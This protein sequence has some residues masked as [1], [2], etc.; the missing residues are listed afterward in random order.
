MMKRR[1]WGILVVAASIAC[2]SCAAIADD[3][4]TSLVEAEVGACVPYVG[5]WTFWGE[6]SG[7][8]G[9]PVGSEVRSMSWGQVVLVYPSCGGYAGRSVRVDHGDGRYMYAHIDAAVSTGQWL[10]PGQ[11]VGWVYGGA[12]PVYCNA[13]L[14][15]CG[16]GWSPSRT[17]LCW[18]GPHLHREGPCCGAEPATDCGTSFTVVGGIREKWQSLGGCGWGRP[19]T[20]E[21]AAANGGRFSHFDNGA[22]IYWTPWIGAREVHG[23]IRDH[24]AWLGWEWSWL[25]YP[26]SDEYQYDGTPWGM[27]GWVAE[28][29]FEGGWLSYEFATGNIVEWPR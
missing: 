22:S 2:A 11:L 6:C 26:I 19:E 1:I 9:L 18:S 24:W 12:G 5:H 14:S 29:E 21:G 23:R 27:A 7:D 25:G 16:V 20:D 3:D 8:V 28:S 13:S 17:T 10:A 4:E 15:S